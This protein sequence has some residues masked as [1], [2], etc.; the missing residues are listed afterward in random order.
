MQLQFEGMLVMGPCSRSGNE[1]M[2]DFTLHGNHPI[3]GKR[4]LP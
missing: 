1:Q 2:S 4:H 3:A